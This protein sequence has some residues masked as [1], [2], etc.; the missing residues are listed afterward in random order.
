MAIVVTD[1]AQV[2]VSGQAKP[3]FLR[4]DIFWKV[5]GDP[6][7]T[8]VKLLKGRSEINRLL[9]HPLRAKGKDKRKLQYTSILETIAQLRNDRINSLVTQSKTKEQ[10]IDF[11]IDDS[12]KS[13]VASLLH[14]NK[15]HGSQL[16][17]LRLSRS[18]V[19]RLAIRSPLK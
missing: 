11:N 8:Y 4:P 6:V 13:V 9:G 18:I 2:S 10:K 3:I 14:V 12:E 19:L 7:L 16:T 1:I 17:Y 5:P 15:G